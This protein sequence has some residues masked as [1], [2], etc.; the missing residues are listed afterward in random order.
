MTDEATDH[1]EEHLR[2]VFPEGSITRV[3]VLRYGDDPAVEPGDTGI[4]VVLS[5]AGRPEGKDGDEE[6][7]RTFEEANRTAIRQLRNEL[8]GAVGWVEF[9]PDRPAG[10]GQPRGP[11]LRIKV[12][13]PGGRAGSL[14]DVADELT[15]VMTRLGTADLATVDTLITAGIANSRAE[16]IRWALGRI[17]EN[18]AYTELQA[19]VH[20]I[21]ELKAQF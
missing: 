16:V 21:D 3:E 15:P 5:R 11:I 19:R 1:V 13:G 4:R 14:D 12:G 2:S 8:P 6:T 7:V 10:A 20:E 17:R 9:R 18:P